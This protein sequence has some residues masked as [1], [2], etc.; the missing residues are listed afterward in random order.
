MVEASNSEVKVVLLGESGV[1]KSCII[2]QF[3]DHTFNPDIDPSISSK[4]S[5]KLIEIKN[6]DKALKFNL[7]DTAGQ[8]KYRSLVKIF[9]KDAIFIVLVYD[10]TSQT[11]FENLKTY[12]YKEVKSN[13]LS[14]AIFAIVGNKIDL[15]ENSQVS[16][17]EARFF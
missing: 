10:I 13:C 16:E 14:N 15:Y 4:F 8:E 5:S 6:T 7:W 1:G 9:Y 11:S 12:W 17:N 3:V 2:K